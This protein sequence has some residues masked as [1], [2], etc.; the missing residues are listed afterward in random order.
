M[1]L[2]RLRPT[3]K[4][5]TKKDIIEYLREHYRYNTM[6]SWNASTSYAHCVKINHMKF[7]DKATEDVAWDV[8]CASD[9]MPVYWEIDHILQDFAA[10]HDWRWQ[11][12]SNGR[13]GGYLVLGHGGKKPSQYKSR[14]T[15]CGQLNCKPATEDDRKCGNCGRDDRVDIPQPN[16]QHFAQPGM[17]LDMGEDFHDWSLDDLKDRLELVWDFDQTVEIVI[18]AFIDFCRHHQVVE[19]EILVKKTVQVAQERA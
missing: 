2:N 3:R 14:C 19:E 7:P 1:K 9:H 15:V 16:W 13:S 12:W 11:I 4:P 10:R 8:V 18:A 6:N 5:R 17:S